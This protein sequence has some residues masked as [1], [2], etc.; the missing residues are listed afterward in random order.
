M[1]T[2]IVWVHFNRFGNKRGAGDVWTVRTKGRNRYVKQVKVRIPMVTR[3][4]GDAARQ[5][6]AYLVGRGRVVVRGGV[7]TIC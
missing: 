6:R 4:R 3:Y 1:A 2:S 7:A 5:P